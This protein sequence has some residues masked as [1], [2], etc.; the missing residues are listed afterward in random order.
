MK[1]QMMTMM[2][3]LLI[4]S[5]GTASA[6][7]YSRYSNDEL[8]RMKGTMQN[9]D[10]QERASYRTEWRKR[11]ASMNPEERRLQAK[12]N[13]RQYNRCGPAAMKDALGLSDAQQT[14]LQE[15]RDKQFAAAAKERSKLMSLREEMLNESMKKHPDNR[16]IDMLTKKI[17]TTHAGLARMRSNHLQD[18]ASILTTDQA[19]KMKTFMQN[20]PGKK[21][22]RMML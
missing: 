3:V 5:A 18:M 10:A 8:S 22:G 13:L 17:G 4:G 1:K 16:K 7:D 19:E 15:L 6:A 14:R 9:A 2:A 11:I 20:K 21:H 12:K